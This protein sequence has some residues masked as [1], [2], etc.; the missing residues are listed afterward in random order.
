MRLVQIVLQ[1]NS[2]DTDRIFNNTCH[3]VFS[4]SMVVPCCVF[5]KSRTTLKTIHLFMAFETEV[6]SLFLDG[7][8]IEWIW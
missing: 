6:H 8:M 5:Y 7:K 2:G 4:P 1:L 3:P